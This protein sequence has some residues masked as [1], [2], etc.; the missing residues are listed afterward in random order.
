[1]D[2]VVNQL[3]HVNEHGGKA[4]FGDIG[5]FGLNFFYL[6]E[7]FYIFIQSCQLNISAQIMRDS[8]LQAKSSPAQVRTKLSWASNRHQNAN[9]C[10]ILGSGT[11]L[12]VLNTVYYHISLLVINGLL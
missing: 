1:V 2:A 11:F 5:G 4:G 8:A 9:Q 6:I 3:E 7:L 10:A 12:G